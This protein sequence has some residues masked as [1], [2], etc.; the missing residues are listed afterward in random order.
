MTIQH[1]LRT[2]LTRGL[3]CLAVS[4]AAAALGQ[5]S[6][7]EGT[8]P[9]DTVVLEHARGGAYFVAEPLKKAYDGLVARTRA[10]EADLDADRLSGP[11]VLAELKGLQSKLAE[12]RGEIDRK[13]VLVAPVKVHTQT[14]ETT[15]DLGPE[16]LLVVTADHVRVLGW[17]GPSVKCVLEKAVLAPDDKPVDEHLAGLRVD[18]KH[19]PAREVVGRSAA[20]VE[21]DEQ[22]FLATDDGK[23]LDAKRRENRRRFV[24]EIA[25]SYAA[26][27]AFQGT[28]VDTVEVA[29]LTHEG[30]NRQ[31]TVHVK[32]PGGGGASMGSDWQRHAMLT[33]YVPAGLKALAV[34]GCLGSLDV[35][36]VRGPLLLTRDGSRDRDYN[37]TFAVRDVD[38][39]L[40]VREAPLD[41]I[42]GVR[43]DVTI[44][45]TTELVNTGTTHDAAAGTRTLYTPPPR[46]LTIRGVAGDL[47]A[48][49]ARAD[50]T[51][52]AVG[53][54]VDVVNEFGNTTW[55]AAKP[56]AGD[57]GTKPL[58]AKPHRVL[59]G[60]GRAEVR[61]SAKAV[62]ALPVQALT[63]CGTVKTNAPQAALEDT[64]FGTA[65]G[66][67]T[68]TARDWRG[69]KSKPAGDRPGAFLGAAE[70]LGAVLA[71]G[72][73]SEGVDVISRGGM[74][75][76]WWAE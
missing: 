38:G 69:L 60:S 76:V 52:E 73:R 53:G 58:A 62:G 31:I 5:L 18:H 70:R 68:D 4:P 34:R 39:P 6:E 41:V 36:G 42:E 54:R 3:L 59:S 15:F 8:A 50:L 29:G 45:S 16:R 56:S 13:K 75:R 10:L 19:G 57:A 64:S 51:V 46:A 32:S 14:A 40:T 37:G 67:G 24:G 11:E 1:S 74:V 27:A 21:A 61:L 49:F 17:D 26:Y 12:L 28:A 72:E 63:N 47:T 25:A 65:P 43:G 2:T 23:K 48:R 35:R 44:D 33:V 71:G 22:K 7:V 30:G 66:V 20:E 9:P 55:N